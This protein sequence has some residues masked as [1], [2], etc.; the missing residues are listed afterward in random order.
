MICG[1]SR[2]LRRLECGADF[3]ELLVAA[4]CART[5]HSTRVP[6]CVRQASLPD[7]TRK[8]VSSALKKKENR[9]KKRTVWKFHVM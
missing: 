1:H 6:A 2:R 5:S 7:F 9:D 8:R 3:V 4:P